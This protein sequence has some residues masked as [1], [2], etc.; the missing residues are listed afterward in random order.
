MKNLYIILA[1]ILVSCSKETINENPN[2]LGTWNLVA[3]YDGME[4]LIKTDNTGINIT[5]D[6]IND[7]RFM[8]LDPISYDYQRNGTE[9]N[10]QEGKY[11]WVIEQRGDSLL[12]TWPSNGFTNI[13]TKGVNQCS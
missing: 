9:L 4:T 11:V 3:T 2:M 10:I 7:C 1:I 12:L 13:F 8:N 5:T 6:K